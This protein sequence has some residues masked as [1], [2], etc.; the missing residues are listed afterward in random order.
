MKAH[1]VLMLTIAVNDCCNGEGNLRRWRNLVVNCPCEVICW[2][3]TPKGWRISGDNQTSLTSPRLFIHIL[4]IAWYTGIRYSSNTKD[5][6]WFRSEAYMADF[7]VKNPL[8]LLPRKAFHLFQNGSP[9]S[10]RIGYVKA[11]FRL[12]GGDDS[13]TVLNW[14]ASTPLARQCK[15]HDS[16]W[17]VLLR[18]CPLYWSC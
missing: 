6:W 3:V 9:H 10:S 5:T 17:F 18:I 11:G 14:L 7:S 2:P 16:L 13:N 12:Q 1:P 4:I 15:F 8:N